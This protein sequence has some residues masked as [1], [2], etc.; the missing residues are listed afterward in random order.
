MRNV[1]KLSL[2]REVGTAHKQPHMSLLYHYNVLCIIFCV[3]NHVHIILY[4]VIPEL[5]RI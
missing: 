5:Y 3:Y 1:I 2:E 4:T